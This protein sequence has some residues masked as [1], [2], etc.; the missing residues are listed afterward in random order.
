MSQPGTT[1]TDD[2]STSLPEA[3]QAELA[4]RAASAPNPVEERIAVIEDSLRCFAYGWLS[5]IP[6]V[7]VAYVF[8][9]VRRFLQA[10]RRKVEWNPARGYLAAGM[11]LTCVGWL[12][13]L[14]SWILG[15]A[16]LMDLADP[17]G[18]GVPVANVVLGFL[19]LT[20]PALLVGLMMA[21]RTVWP[22]L[23]LDKRWW[24]WGLGTLSV[25]FCCGILTWWFCRLAN[26]GE[27]TLAWGTFLFLIVWGSWLLGGF[28]ILALRQAG[29]LAWLAW[30]GILAA[31]TLPFLLI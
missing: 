10:S 31:L 8:P 13:G 7:G 14:V 19:L 3:W 18:P 15:L 12:V 29:S 30:L 28:V 23:R 27:T 5:C 17:T 4:R 1:S 20:S 9:A 6:L 21:A 2:F 11:L 25:V 16:M 22:G 24:Q 26:H